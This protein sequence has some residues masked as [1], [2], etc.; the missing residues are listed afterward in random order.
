M[1]ESINFGFEFDTHVA[2][3]SECQVRYEKGSWG[4]YPIVTIDHLCK[5]G[6]I[7]HD[8]ENVITAT[9]TISLD[10]VR[11][12]RWFWGKHEEDDK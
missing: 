7:I 9:P 2:R 4:C 3:C 6:Q 12:R 10:E 5:A 11:K 1:Q 8:A